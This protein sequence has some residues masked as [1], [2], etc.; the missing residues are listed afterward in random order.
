M[1]GFD[2]AHIQ[3]KPD[4][5]CKCP[6]SKKLFHEYICE[7][8][9]EFLKKYRED[10]EDYIESLSGNELFACCCHTPETPHDESLKF[11]L[12]K[13]KR[14]DDGKLMMNLPEGSII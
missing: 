8:A 3:H 4:V 5:R 2:S 9:H 14:Q 6:N 10:Y 11:R 7:W 13:N 1:N 12:I